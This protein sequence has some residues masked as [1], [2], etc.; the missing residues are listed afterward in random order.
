MTL[1]LFDAFN[2][3]IVGFFCALMALGLSL[4]LGLNNVINFAHGGF[5]ALGGY[6]AFTL[7]PWIGFWGAW[8]CARSW[9]RH[10]VWWR[11]GV[12]PAALWAR[13][14]VSLLLTFGLAMILEDVIRTTWGAAGVPFSIPAVLNSPVSSAYFFVTG[15]R[16]LVVG[17]TAVAVAA[18]FLVLR[19]TRLGVC[20]RAGNADLETV[21]SLGVNV[22][23]LRAAICAGDPAGGGRWYFGGGA[24]G[25]DADDGGRR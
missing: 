8:C 5:M 25:A 6:F 18:L 12:C 16:V 2:G 22:Y 14:A 7:E 1:L 23:L 13:S 9:W 21:A 19:Y 20:I 3:L 4:I 17:I 15:Y 10:W 24:T 11:S